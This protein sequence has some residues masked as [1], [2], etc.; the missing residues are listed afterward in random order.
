[1]KNI[2]K[3]KIWRIM[4]YISVLSLLVACSDR[5]LPEVGSPSEAESKYKN[6]ELTIAV[7]KQWYESHYPSV[8]TI[9]EHDAASKKLIRPMWDKAKEYNR[10][11]YEVVETPIQ[12]KGHH[13]ITDVETSKKW[14]PGDKADFVRNAAR[15]VILY[16]KKT[17][18]TRSFAMVFVGSYEYL[19]TNHPIERNS[20]LYREPDFDGT[21]FFYNLNGT[22]SNG[23]KYS[24]G[25]IV[26]T[27]S[28]QPKRNSASTNLS[29]QDAIKQYGIGKLEAY[30]GTWVY[31]SNDTVFK[32]FLQKGCTSLPEFHYNTHKIFGSYYLSVSGKV[33]DDY[34]GDLPEQLVIVSGTEFKYPDN[35]CIYASN[36]EH[37]DSLTPP[38]YMGMTYYDKRKRHFDGKGIS[39]GYMKLLSPNEILWHLDEK[40]GIWW[41]TEGTDKAVNPIGFSVP[42]DVILKKE[43]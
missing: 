12:S 29:A 8:V 30:V 41:E 33:L 28:R 42:N 40:Q 31:Q 22:F 17:K 3:C 5:L 32:I 2:V 38:P 39:G 4:A 26:G 9:R 6:K 15:F 36:V 24:N 20:Y 34:R 7:A 18:K 23:W 25:K 43:E 11:R 14:K 10:R 19:R 37:R 27:I 35:L 16:D 21:V 1:M 13:L